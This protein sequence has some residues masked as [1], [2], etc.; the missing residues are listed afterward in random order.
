MAIV[1]LIFPLID[2]GGL[3]FPGGIIRY[4]LSECVFVLDILSL[5]PLLPEAVKFLHFALPVLTVGLRRNM[6]VLLDFLVHLLFQ[7]ILNLLDL[8]LVVVIHLLGL[9]NFLLD[10]L[11]SVLDVRFGL[12]K[13]HLSLLVFIEYSV[14]HLHMAL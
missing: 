13:D 9:N 8:V 1:G 2:L 3:N 12:F 7:N 10:V 14:P 11:A 4:S 6:V 5:D